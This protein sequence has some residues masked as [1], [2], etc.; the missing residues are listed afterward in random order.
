MGFEN[1]PREQQNNKHQ[2]ANVKRGRYYDTAKTS[3]HERRDI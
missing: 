3:H 1:I 2:T